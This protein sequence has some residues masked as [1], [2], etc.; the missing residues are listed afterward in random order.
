MTYAELIYAKT[1][2]NRPVN[3]KLT[4]PEVLQNYRFT[5][6]LIYLFFV[7]EIQ[8]TTL[9]KHSPSKGKIC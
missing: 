7:Y 5:A 3:K 4:K 9:Q 1:S 6:G 2:E 8:T